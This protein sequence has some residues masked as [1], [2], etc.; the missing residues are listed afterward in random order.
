MLTM[1]VGIFLVVGLIKHFNPPEKSIAALT[2]ACKRHD[3]KGV[4]TYVDAESLSPSMRKFLKDALEAKDKINAKQQSNEDVS[5]QFLG[6]VLKPVGDMIL[7][8]IVDKFVTPE[9]L[10]NMLSGGSVHETMQKSLTKMTDEVTDTSVAMASQKT[11]A[12]TPAIKLALGVCVDALLEAGDAQNAQQSKAP[13]LGFSEKDIKTI[14]LYEASD[15]YVVMYKA[16]NPDIPIIAMVYERHG[17]TV[18]KWSEI[19]LLPNDAVN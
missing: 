17:W 11:K 2:A 12:Y 19:R 13:D 4:E 7:S 14:T 9:N 10:L 6:A 8:A 15:R 18:W 1:G 5:D 3:R 16:P